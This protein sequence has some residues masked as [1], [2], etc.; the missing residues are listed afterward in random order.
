MDLFTYLMKKKGR[1]SSVEG[2]LFSYLLAN[3]GNG[4][5][6]NYT[7]ETIN[8]DN[9]VKARMKNWNLGGNTSQE[10]TPT[11][12]TPQDIH[13]VKGENN[14]IENIGKNLFY[15]YTFSQNN[16]GVSFVTKEGYIE[17]NGKALNDAYSMYSN[18]AQDKLITLEAGTYCISGATNLVLLDV[19]RSNGQAIITTTSSQTYAVFTLF[20]TTKIF[21]RARVLKDNEV[22]N[23]KIYP[24]LETGNTPT[25]YEK[26]KGKNYKV[27]LSSKNLVDTP[28]REFS[29]TYN[30]QY[31]VQSIVLNNVVKLEANKQYTFQFKIKSDN[32]SIFNKIYLYSTGFTTIKELTFYEKTTK[33][34]VKKTATFT[35]N[36][37]AELTRI[38]FQNADIDT[39]YFKDVEIE[40]GNEATP[41][42]PYLNIELCKIGDY[43]DRIYKSND[44]WYLEKNIEKITLNGSESWS[45]ANATDGKRY[46]CNDNSI[47][48]IPT[49]QSALPNIYCDKFISESANST[50]N[51][52]NGI[53]IGSSGK[54][55]IYYD[56]YK[57]EENTSNFKSWLS[58][59]NLTIYGSLITPIITEITNEI[60]LSQ[61]NELA[62]AKSFNGQTNIT[63]ISEDLPFDL[64]VDIKTQ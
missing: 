26:Y 3:E 38:G 64:S 15:P 1:N 29:K 19:I 40:I 50:N 9:S 21:I 48:T 59:N 42:V 22:D 17:A 56:L 5:Y 31:S 41:Y 10:G 57:N 34:F 51:S 63:Q 60:L 18:D 43:Q 35:L 32:A 53:G 24:Q 13:V 7:G 45:I 12:T 11:P 39:F 47:F 27:S 2:D 16:S 33:Q 14:V 23:V 28:D 44:K 36:E 55:V 52:I 20:E 30:S 58:Q 49:S 62:K 8:V 46:V 4:S 37:D 6:V 54:L 61:L 25:E